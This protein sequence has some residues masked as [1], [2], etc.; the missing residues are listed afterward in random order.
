MLDRL[1]V[2]AKDA[3][4]L[5][6]LDTAAAALVTARE[7]AAEAK[8]CAEQVEDMVAEL[9]AKTDHGQAQI[10]GLG[11]FVRHAGRERRAWDHER[12]RT[13]VVRAAKDCACTKVH[14]DPETGEVTKESETEH[15]VRH[16]AECMGV[17]YWKKGGLAPLFLEADDYAETTW[18]RPTVRVMK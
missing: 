1:I 18:G 7:I 5:G 13:D 17:S 6:D 14:V 15:V 2:T 12:A 10:E 3:K 9:L 4:D 11:T 16:L 8:A